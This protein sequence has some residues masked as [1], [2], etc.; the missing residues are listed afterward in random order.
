MAAAVAVAERQL[1]LWKRG[2]VCASYRERKL[3]AAPLKRA[4]LLAQ[5]CLCRS[6]IRFVLSRLLMLSVAFVSLFMLIFFPPKVL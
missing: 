6:C 3:P 5:A 1:L 2:F 4:K